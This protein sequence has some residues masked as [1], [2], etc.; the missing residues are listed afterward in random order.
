MIDS[1][2]E[3]TRTYIVL[4]NDEEQYSLWLKGKAIPPGWSQVGSEGSKADCLK[5]VGENWTDMR[6]RSVR[7]TGALS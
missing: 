2:A 6:P 3:D 7:T 5:F 4:V 1:E